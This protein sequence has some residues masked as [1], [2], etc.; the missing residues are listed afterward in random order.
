MS[1]SAFSWKGLITLVQ[2]S[3]ASPNP[4]SS[5]SNWL[6]L[7]R[8]RQLSQESPTKSASV[9]SCRGLTT[10][11]QLSRQFG[12]PSAS[13]SGGGVLWILKLSKATAA[14]V[15]S[16]LSVYIP[17]KTRVGVRVPGGQRSPPT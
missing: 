11:V 7:A 15:P 4:S 13:P 3:Q 12:T 17:M 6:L 1:E 2:L 9:S 8:K 16:V 5:A 10:A 14:A